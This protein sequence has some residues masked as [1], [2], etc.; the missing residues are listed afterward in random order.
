MQFINLSDGVPGAAFTVLS[1]RLLFTQLP[2]VVGGF[3]GW[4]NP[5]RREVPI[6]HPER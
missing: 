4:L 3:K 2:V 6:T 5:T 1:A